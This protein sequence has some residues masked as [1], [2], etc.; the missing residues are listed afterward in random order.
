MRL[1]LTLADADAGTSVDLLVQ[2]PQGS[3]VCDLRPHLPGQPPH[4]DHRPDLYAGS[5]RLA[6]DAELGHPPL[7][8]GAVIHVGRPA[9]ISRGVTGLLHLDVTS[10]PDAGGSYALAS[11][12]HVVGR[13]PTVQVRIEDPEL[14]RAHL[15]VEV[16]DSTTQVSDLGTTNGSRL[17]DEPLTSTPRIWPLGVALHAGGS[18]LELR[19]HGSPSAATTFDGAGGISINRRPRDVPSRPDVVV[20]FPDAP[21]LGHADA[22]R[23]WP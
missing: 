13:S 7:L 15:L 17:G 3:Q 22:C 8:D 12:S 4:A 10:G 9:P 19:T 5:W 2:A 11:G 23:C 6:D 16:S 18:L 14:S 21:R 20:T 1:W